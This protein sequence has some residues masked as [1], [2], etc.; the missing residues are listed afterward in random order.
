MLLL[1][2][3]LLCLER[4]HSDFETLHPSLHRALGSLVPPLR[5][6]LLL[7][8]AT[9][10]WHRTAWLCFWELVANA[11]YASALGARPPVPASDVVGDDSDVAALGAPP[12]LLLK[13]MLL[14]LLAMRDPVRIVARSAARSRRGCAPIRTSFFGIVLRP[15]GTGSLQQKYTELMVHHHSF[16][17]RDLPDVI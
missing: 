10:P 3:L 7:F 15:E 11:S 2:T 8:S 9:L 14:L 13:M 17:L 5:F 4:I 1:E 12:V 6:S 16:H